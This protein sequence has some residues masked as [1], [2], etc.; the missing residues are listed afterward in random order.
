VAKLAAPV[1]RYKLICI[2][3]APG[4]TH[5]ALPMFQNLPPTF[6]AYCDYYATGEGQTVIVAMSSTA[7]EAIRL[8]KERA[9][10]HFFPDIEIIALGKDQGSSVSSVAQWL[11][12]ELLVRAERGPISFFGIFHQNLS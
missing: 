10:P 11:P 12:T 7:E 8:F 4:P 2:H 1:S 5:M 6:A 9:P 3:P